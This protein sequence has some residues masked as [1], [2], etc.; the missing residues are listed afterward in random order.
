MPVYKWK[1]HK[2]DAGL[3]GMLL[4]SADSVS[5]ARSVAETYLR[6]R[7]GWTNW[8]WRDEPEE[9]DLTEPRVLAVVEHACIGNKV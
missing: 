8:F 7:G 3:I 2:P 5:A 1:M 4:V 9:L 6:T